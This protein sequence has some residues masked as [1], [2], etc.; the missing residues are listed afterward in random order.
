MFKKVMTINGNTL[1]I[2]ELEKFIGKK[3]E[4]T[5]KE[6]TPKKKKANNLMEFFGTLEPAEDPLEFQKKARAEWNEREKS[7]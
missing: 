3:V 6:L 4:I 1:T 2:P 7:F 5:L